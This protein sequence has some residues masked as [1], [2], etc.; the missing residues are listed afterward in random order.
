MRTRRIKKLLVAAVVAGT[1]GGAVSA[2]PASA[3]CV[4]AEAYYRRSGQTNQYIIGPKSC[5]VNTPFG[6]FVEVGAERGV[7]PVAAAGARVW[8]PAP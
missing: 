8:L 6:H 3:S 1:L 4:Y 5:V 7:E 2:V